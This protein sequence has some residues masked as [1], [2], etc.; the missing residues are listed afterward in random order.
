MT[1]QFPALRR[2]GLV[3]LLA[4]AS[5]LAFV[6]LPGS[7]AEPV[8][9]SVTVYLVYN[10]QESGRKQQFKA[11]DALQAQVAAALQNSGTG[12]Y[13]GTGTSAGDYL[14]YLSGPSA[15]A[16]FKAVEPVLKKSALSKGGKVALRYGGEGAKE[17]EKT[18]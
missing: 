12:E 6:V 5:S 16:M 17:V 13:A 3:C 8:R 4:L 9:Q 14:M 1:A 11:C 18:L 10:G 2:I 7:A 15:D